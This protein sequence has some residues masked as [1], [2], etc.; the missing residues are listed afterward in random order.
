MTSEAKVFLAGV[1]NGSQI[2]TEVFVP[3]LQKALNGEGTVDDLFAQAQKDATAL[4][5]K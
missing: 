1:H 5:T 2:N 4:L 3:A